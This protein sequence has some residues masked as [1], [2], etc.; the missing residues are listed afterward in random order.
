METPEQFKERFAGIMR[1]AF[2][3]SIEAE[4]EKP[5]KSQAIDWVV[6]LHDELRQRLCAL[7]PSRSDDISDHMDNQLFSQRLKANAFGAEHFTSLVEYTFETLKEIVSPDMDSDMEEK[8]RE[9]LD[10]IKPGALFS[11]Q[12]PLFLKHSHA[13]LDES[14]RRIME[15]KGQ[16]EAAA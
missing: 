1:Q 4:L 3:D 11:K 7:R 16:Y 8:R 10:G 2:F 13:L 14:I 9:V 12:V 15:L 6:R 5:D